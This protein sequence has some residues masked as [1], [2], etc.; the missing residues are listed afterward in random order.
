MPTKSLL[1][2]DVQYLDYLRTRKTFP[3]HIHW[4]GS[5]P[6]EDIFAMAQTRGRQLVLPEVD[7][8][9][10]PIPYISKRERLINSVETLRRFQMDLRHYRIID[11]FAVPISFMQTKQDLIDTAVAH[12]RY[13]KS[14]NS[15]YAE[16]RFAPQYHTTEGLALDQVIGSALEGF[17]KGREETGVVVKL[18]ISIGREADPS[19]GKEVVKAALRYQGSVVGIDLACEERGNPPEKHYPAFALTFDSSLKRTIHAGEMCGEEENL[20]NIYTAITLL[21]ANGISHAIPLHKKNY[22]G[23][24]LIDLMIKGAIRLEANPICNSNFFIDD[25][26]NLHL[27][28]LMNAGVLVT[29]NPDDPAMWQNGDLVYNLYALGK[30]YGDGFVQAAIRNSILAAWGL[31]AAEKQRYLTAFELIS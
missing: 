25:I 13:L 14:Q 5:I 17:E 27:E 19:V 15:P 8:D 6:A 12:C 22:Q 24:N 7:I 10:N 18:I 26:A 4:D 23:H 29:I 2:D 9:E 16:S 28:E 21:R 1:I 30:M 3:L 11:V 31:S 20:K